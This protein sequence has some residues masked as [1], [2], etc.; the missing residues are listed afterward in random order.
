MKLRTGR[1]PH[2]WVSQFGGSAWTAD[3]KTQQYYLHSFLA[4]QPD[5][6][7]RNPEVRDAMFE[8][9][10]FW[11]DR[12]VDGFRVDVLWLL[13]KDAFFRNNPPNPDYHGGMQDLA[14]TLPVF[15]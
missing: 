6:N 9:L 5:L 11:L 10:R 8:V 7:W 13:I 15:T 2:N 12:G 4:Q 1:P 3:P 14:S